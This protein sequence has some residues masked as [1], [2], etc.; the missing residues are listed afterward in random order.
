MSST[1]ASVF[2]F[3]ILISDAVTLKDGADGRVCLD[4]DSFYQWIWTQFAQKGLVGVHEGTL[5]VQ[6][7]AE[8]GLGVDLWTLDAGEAPKDRDWVGAQSEVL[9]EFYFAS[10]EEACDASSALLEI[11]DLKIGPVQEQKPR[12]WDAEW[13]AS[14]LNAGEG[15]E[16]PPF[17]RV[18]PPWVAS[19]PGFLKINPGAGFGTGTHEATQLCLQLIG[20]HS[21]VQSLSETVALDFGSGSGILAIALARLGA[22]VNAVEIDSLAID[23]AVENAQLNAVEEQISFYSEIPASPEKY[24]FIVANI[25]RHTLLEFSQQLA[26]R[27]A[28]GGRL[29]LSGLMEADVE[30]IVK[31]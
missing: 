3:S 17:W 13:K 1:T 26:A 24:P 2:T 12:D 9:T 4:R 23:N 20:E 14:F 15:V 30:W 8:Q 25:L 27:L 5:L 7:A 21:Q 28:P 31:C 16:I 10:L 18:V 19:Q 29:V 22:K 11:S 6:E